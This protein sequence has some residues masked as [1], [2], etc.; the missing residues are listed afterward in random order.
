MTFVLYDD[1]REW[2]GKAMQNDDKGSYP[3]RQV[4]QT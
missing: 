1:C 2:K 3:F 4:S